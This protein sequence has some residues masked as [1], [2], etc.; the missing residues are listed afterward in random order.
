MKWIYNPYDKDFVLYW[1]GE[2]YKLEAKDYTP[3]P[4]NV[5]DGLIPS[6]KILDPLLPVDFE[7]R[8]IALRSI[9]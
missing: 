9:L 6:D 7:R 4:E 5:L 3:L 8:M 1:N 2:K